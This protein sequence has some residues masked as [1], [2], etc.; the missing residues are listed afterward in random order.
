MAAEAT[1]RYIPYDTNQAIVCFTSSEKEKINSYMP[2][3]MFKS[4]VC[5]LDEKYDN[6]TACFKNIYRRV[7]LRLSERNI[8]SYTNYE[9]DDLLFY[10]YAVDIGRKDYT[11]RFQLQTISISTY[12]FLIEQLYYGKIG[13][14]IFLNCTIVYLDDNSKFLNSH[15]MGI[16][17]TKSSI[18]GKMDIKVYDTSNYDNY[19]CQTMTQELKKLYDNLSN[20]DSSSIEQ[21]YIPIKKENT[22]DYEIQYMTTDEII[23]KYGYL[24]HKKTEKPEWENEEYMRLS[25]QT[26]LSE[27][28]NPF[29]DSDWGM[30]DLDDVE[31][32]V[33]V[34]D[35][36][37][38]PKKSKDK[39]DMDFS[40]LKPE[41]EEAI[42]KMKEDE[43]L[44]QLI[45]E[46]FFENYRIVTLDISYE[47][48]EYLKKKN[49]FGNVSIQDGEEIFNTGMCSAWTLYFIVEIY[50]N[51]KT[52]Y[53]VY[54]LILS[55]NTTFRAKF[56]YVWYDLLLFALNIS[57]ISNGDL[58][59]L[60]VTKITNGV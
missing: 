50:I 37:D 9:S 21:F 34:V 49:F 24:P 55:M 58:E 54:D 3:A 44:N 57:N 47:F 4:Y 6:Q 36:L 15:I 14:N 32:V 18:Y 48:N 20:L 56:I 16:S 27:E 10:A 33:D 38:I 22:L 59:S 31:D 41:E 12:K 8:F 2:R 42:R 17:I 28:E 40:P 1:Y 29:G 7:Y 45:E 26:P 30:T 60:S 19:E 52:S 5:D 46:S 25:P 39:E 11:N 51:K 35:V 53:D 13:S 23:K 43:K